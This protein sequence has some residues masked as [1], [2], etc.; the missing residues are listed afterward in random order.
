MANSE[1][2]ISADFFSSIWI[3][4]NN[5]DLISIHK[6]GICEVYSFVEEKEKFQKA[7]RIIDLFDF[8]GKLKNR[9]ITQGL[10]EAKLDI[11]NIHE[12]IQC[13]HALELNEF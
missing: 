12:L 4:K 7:L 13:E 5:K 6:R 8:M 1:I 3:G 2:I 10:T 9:I 11:L